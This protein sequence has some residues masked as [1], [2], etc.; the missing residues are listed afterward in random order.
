MK[1]EVRPGR[2]DVLDKAWEFPHDRDVLVCAVELVRVS[3]VAVVHFIL[4]MF[5]N[6]YCVLCEREL[7]HDVTKGHW[8][9]LE[10]IT[11]VRVEVW[12]PG[13]LVRPSVCVSHM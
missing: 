5:E 9:F 7:E 8:E 6:G 3:I 13:I 2:A 12:Q 11:V 4:P 10:R 1:V